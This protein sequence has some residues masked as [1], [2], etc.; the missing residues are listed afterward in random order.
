MR[1]LLD[2]LELFEAIVQHPV[3]RHPDVFSPG[4]FAAAA[5]VSHLAKQGDPTEFLVALGI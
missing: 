2:Y 4:A 5:P 3:K 1:F